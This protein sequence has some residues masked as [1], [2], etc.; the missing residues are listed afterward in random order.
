MIRRIFGSK[1]DENGEWKR[2]HNE[3]LHSLYSSPNIIRIINSRRLRWAC[4]I[5][6]MEEGRRDFKILT[7]KPTGK[8]LS[9]KL[10]VDGRKIL[11]W[12]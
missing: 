10:E 4:H 3:E 11:E 9:A 12:T 1:R 5:A 2:L 6:R 8:R 7:S